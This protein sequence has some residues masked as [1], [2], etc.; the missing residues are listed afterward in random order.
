MANT[1]ASPRIPQTAAPTSGSRETTNPAANT[2][3]GAPPTAAAAPKGSSASNFIGLCQALNEYEEEKVKEGVYKI[4]NQYEVI[5]HPPELAKSTVSKP[6]LTNKA[7]T[8]SQTGNTAKE[9]VDPSTNAVETTAR[10]MS[11]ISGT[12]IVQFIEQTMRNSSYITNQ[13]THL[14]DEV[15]QEEK[16]NKNAPNGQQ[17]TW[18]KI[19]VN[20]ESLGYDENRKDNAY[21]MTYMVTPF[22]INQLNSQ[23]F[24]DSRFR[25]VHK[26]YNYWFTGENNA[27]LHFEQQYNSQYLT[28]LSGKNAVQNAPNTEGMIQTK[29]VAQTAS[30]QSDKGAAGK[31][32][33]PAANA[34]DYLY[35]AADQGTVKIKI[36]GDPAWIQQGEVIGVSPTT[37][38]FKEF[39][40]DGTINSDASQVVFMINW[41]APADYNL[42]TGLMSVDAQTRAANGATGDSVPQLTAAYRAKSVTSTF[43]RGKF[44]QEVEGALLTNLK[45]SNIPQGEGRNSDTTSQGSTDIRDSASN[46]NAIANIVQPGR[47]PASTPN[48][49]PTDQNPPALPAKPATSP[50]SNGDIQPTSSLSP[51]ETVVGV[52]EPA[53]TNQNLA[54]ET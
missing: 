32:N 37:F 11:V 13:Q 3:A 36:I 21:K 34:A 25:G 51:G 38:S 14:I 23:Y 52:N 7:L 30:G 33:E 53:R 39:L 16:P 2:S 4:A 6:G 10:T 48:S 28:V 46:P 40:P 19:N 5:F 54:T 35:S 31:T 47:T 15:T 12:Q 27:V 1:N 24:N 43:S 22:G 18:F 50:T 44:E 41:N 20:A 49:Q 9:R 17:T 42:E 8:P 29:R 45:E 26:V